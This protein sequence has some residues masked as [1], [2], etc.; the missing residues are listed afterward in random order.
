MSHQSV[1]E[2]KA[3]AIQWIKEAGELIKS[4]MKKPY[5]VDTKQDRKDL[6]TEVDQKTEQFFIDKILTQYPD[7]QVLGEEGMGDEVQSLNG[8]VWIIDPIDGTMNFVHQERFFA[9]SIGIYFDGIGEIGLIY[10]VMD[11]VLYEGVR[12]EGAF[13]NGK[14]LNPIDPDKHLE[15]A[16]I[17]LNNSWAIPNRKLN[18]EKIHDLVRKVKGTRSY[19]SAA[20]EFAFIAEGIIDAYITM[21]LAPWDIAAGMIIVNEVGGITTRVDG[22]DVNMLTGNTVI[23]ANKAIHHELL[24]FIETK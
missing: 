2:I 20:L 9:I 22:T 19:G 5:E 11:D 21:R 14:Q 10:D 16:L 12:G 4:H 6:V 23:C 17:G 13:K 1:E 15:D 8:V 18:E 3:S 24:D 7:H